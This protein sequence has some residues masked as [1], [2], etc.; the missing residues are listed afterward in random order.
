MTWFEVD[1]A[2]VARASA[3]VRG[4]AEQ[5]EAEV[6]ALLR[7]L[8]E[9]RDGWRGPASASFAEVVDE[10]HATHEQVRRALVEIQ[11]ALALT[12]EEYARAEAT[13]T[14]LFRD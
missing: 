13:A 14:R 12:G 7:Q 8:V 5:I 6:G 10:W 4:A 2:E 11:R 3:T 1:S 9:L